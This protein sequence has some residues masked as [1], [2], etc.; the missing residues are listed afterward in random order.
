MRINHCSI[1]LV[2][3]QQKI[4]HTSSILK[5]FLQYWRILP[6]KV[7]LHCQPWK[8]RHGW[9]DLDSYDPAMLRPVTTKSAEPNKFCPH[10]TN[11]ISSEVGGASGPCLPWWC[12]LTSLRRMSVCKA[13]ANLTRT[14]WQ[15]QITRG[16]APTHAFAVDAAAS[17]GATVASEVRATVTK[18]RAVLGEDDIWGVRAKG[19][20]EEREMKQCMRDDKGS[21]GK[22]QREEL[23]NDSVGWLKAFF[24]MYSQ[25][26]RMIMKV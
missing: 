5:H 25:D 9:F 14:W 21:V 7:D 11:I 23:T 4:M 1:L 2:L 17:E 19:S 22:R 18:G 24:S 13:A 20:D 10:A 6:K 16:T 26:S 8:H 3:G 12:F 15:W